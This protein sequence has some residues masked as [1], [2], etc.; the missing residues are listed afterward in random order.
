[1]MS[2]IEVWSVLGVN[3]MRPLL[4]TELVKFTKRF[5]NFRDA[6]I[7]SL[8]LIA[9]TQ[10]KLTLALQDEARA[11]DWITLE[12]E[13]YGVSDAKLLDESKLSFV[14]MSEGATLIYDNE[15]FA[16]AIGECYNISSIKSSILYII[17]SNIKYKENQF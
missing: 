16:F 13:F 17:A 9:P 11:F 5:A 2:K 7:R 4:Q 3:K 8:E 6:E 10:I 12:L 1:M 15:R 14:D